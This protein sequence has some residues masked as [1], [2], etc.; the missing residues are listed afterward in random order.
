MGVEQFHDV[1]SRII[2]HYWFIETNVTEWIMYVWRMNCML[3]GLA[4]IWQRWKGNRV[5]TNKT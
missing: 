4:G 2:V 3:V 1:F 5:Y